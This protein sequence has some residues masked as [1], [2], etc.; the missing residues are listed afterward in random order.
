MQAVSCFSAKDILKICHSDLKD[1][2]AIK[3]Y[4]RAFSGNCNIFVSTKAY[5]HCKRSYINLPAAGIL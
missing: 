4:F 5:D 3:S 2:Q 1:T